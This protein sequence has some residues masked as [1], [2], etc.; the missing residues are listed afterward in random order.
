MEKWLGTVVVMPKAFYMLMSIITPSEDSSD[1]NRLDQ[2]I[3]NVQ[4]I[5][6]F[7]TLFTCPLP[8]ETTV[9]KMMEEEMSPVIRF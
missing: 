2:V 8:G 7:T 1:Q 6:S 3:N 4:V 9:I 5:V